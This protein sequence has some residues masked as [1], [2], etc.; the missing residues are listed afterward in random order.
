MVVVNSPESLPELLVVVGPTA[1]GKTELASRLCARLDGEIL[2]A[3]SVQVYRHFD[4]GTGKPSASER[5]QTPHHLLDIVEPDQAMDA[6]RWAEL[7]AR[8]ISA[9]T[10][11]GKRPIVC[12]GSFLFVRALLYGLAPAPPASPELRLEHQQRAAREGRARLHEELKLVDPEA[13]AR[14]APNDLMR[15][16][17]ALEVHALTGVALS[18][19]QAEHGF[20]TPHF[21]ARLIGVRRS[22]EELDAR[23]RTRVERMLDAGWIEE[24]AT[25]LARGFGDTRAMGSVGYKQIRQALVGGAPIER[26]ALVNEISR[27]TRVF[28]RRQR[29]WLRD[30]PV[31]YG[32]PGGAERF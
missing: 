20:R 1:S 31:E 26:E 10:A 5:A 17:R 27:A 29:T 2:S 18:R 32:D 12:G 25:L 4:L 22:R 24:V 7:A 11:R 15:V 19:W 8:T 16:S 13:A 3:D 6:A 23:I 28:A 14:L 21:R 9:I 30:E